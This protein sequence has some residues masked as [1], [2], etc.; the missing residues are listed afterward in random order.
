MA[1]GPATAVLELRG[2]RVS[3]RDRPRLEDVD[4]SLAPGERV[5]LLGASGAGKSTLL[6]VANGLLAPATGT[7]LWEGQPPA[8]SRRG[9]RLQQAR[10]GTLWQDL[11]LIEELTVQ[12]N[13][14]AAR[15]AR[16]GWP[17]AVLNLLLPLDTEACAAALRAMDLDP[18]LLEQPVTAL[19]GGQRQRVAMARL[20][21]Q[22]PTLLLADEPLASLD[23]RLAGELLAL[24]LAQ[25]ETPRAL[26]LSLHRPDL[27]DGFDRAVGL[28][29]GRVLFDGPVGQVNPDLL[30]DLYGGTP[31]CAAP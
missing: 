23:P 2:I 17:R 6:A 22:E 11:R 21:R 27:L 10:I 31:P 25:A 3:G 15:L 14:N 18:A 16:W 20:L 26:L 8:R 9:R 1:A 29:D 24:L 4:L 7:V 28:K 12:Q 13:L 5:A 19:S 30:A